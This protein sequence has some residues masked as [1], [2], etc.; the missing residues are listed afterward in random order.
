[1]LYILQYT[2]WAVTFPYP[3]YSVFPSLMF[4]ILQIQWQVPAEEQ[5]SCSLFLLLFGFC[6]FLTKYERPLSL[7]LISIHL[8]PGPS[9]LQNFIFSYCWLVVHCVHVPSFL[10]PVILSPIFG[11]F[12]DFSGSQYSHY[13]KN[14]Q[15]SFHTTLQ[16]HFSEYT[17][18]VQKHNTKK[19]IYSIINNSWFV[20]SS[21]CFL[22]KF[23][24]SPGS[25]VK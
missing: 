4:P 14:Q 1:M 24:L 21:L 6:Y 2:P 16:S 13:S 18:R 3:Y 11:L 7:W 15:L 25:F 10:Y 12:S 5:F 23:L 8:I 17:P 20:L 19:D 22:E 9:K